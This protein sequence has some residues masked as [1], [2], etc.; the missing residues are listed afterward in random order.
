MTMTDSLLESEINLIA[1]YFELS[2]HDTYSSN[3][4]LETKAV[5]E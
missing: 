2:Y 4:Y 5:H 3:I 1:F